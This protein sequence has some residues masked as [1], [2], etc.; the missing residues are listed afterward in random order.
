MDPSWLNVKV[1]VRKGKDAVIGVGRIGPIS[2]HLGSLLGVVE[3]TISC[4]F[5]CRVGYLV[6]QTFSEQYDKLFTGNQIV[7]RLAFLITSFHSVFEKH[8]ANFKPLLLTDST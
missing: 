6:A 7:K 1:V 5:V 3:L 4:A 8:C 2:H